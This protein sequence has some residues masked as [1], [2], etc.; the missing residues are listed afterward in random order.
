MYIFNTLL[1]TQWPSPMH[2]SLYASELLV[3]RL[4]NNLMAGNNTGDHYHDFCL[5]FPVFSESRYS[6]YKIM[7]CKVRIQGATIVISFCWPFPVFSEL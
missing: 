2:F 6:A 1:V 7:L 4:Q 3:F 5:S